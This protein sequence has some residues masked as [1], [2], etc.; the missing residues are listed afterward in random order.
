MK[1]IL[2][3]LFSILILDGCVA[4]QKN[5]LIIQSN[6]NNFLKLS[7]LLEN[8]VKKC[9]KFEESELN[10]SVKIFFNKSITD[11]YLKIA[12]HKKG[13]GFLEKK[14][15]SYILLTEVNNKSRIIIKDE[16]YNC[17]FNQ[18]CDDLKLK[19]NVDFWLTENNKGCLNDKKIN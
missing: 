7:N 8:N 19:E 3:I 4:V 1:R 15:F 13:F 17:V 6:K 18:N 2:L 14:P 10:D 11:K 16:K 12:F 9:Y 5:D